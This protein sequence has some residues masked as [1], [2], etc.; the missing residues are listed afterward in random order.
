MKR[1]RRGPRE[2]CEIPGPGVER[3]RKH[4]P[5]CICPGCGRYGVLEDGVRCCAHAMAGRCEGQCEVT[6]CPNYQNR[7]DFKDYK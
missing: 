3:C 4:S 6:R 2:A 1:T 5:G 7:P